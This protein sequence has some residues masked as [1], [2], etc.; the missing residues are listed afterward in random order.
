MA[1]AITRRSLL[2]RILFVTGS[3]I[4]FTLLFVVA[5]RLAVMQMFRGISASRQTGLAAWNVGNLPTDRTYAWSEA[6]F[7]LSQTG[8][9][10]WIS[11]NADLRMHTEA[12]E[13]CRTSIDHIAAA[14]HGFLDRLVTESHSGYGRALSA[15]LS[16]PAA[17]LDGTLIDLKKL[18]RVESVEESGEDSTV[19]L[20]SAARNLEAAKTSLSRLKSLQRDSKGQLH[21]ALEVEKEI[22]Q[23]DSAVRDAT[24]QR[25]SLLSTVAQAH[26][27]LALLEDFRAPLQMSFKGSLLEIRNSLVEG[28]GNVLSSL[29]TVFGAVLEYGLPVGFWCFVLFWPGRRAWQHFRARL[30]VAQ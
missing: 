8:S 11:R 20:E 23:A 7:Q 21:D 17:E 13:R 27:R 26:I 15:E 30:A 3:F 2:K 25:D 6:S 19:K 12:F 29:T 24:R 9:E 14:H 16:V 18:G 4:V 10:K 1:E 22:A 28:I 5:C